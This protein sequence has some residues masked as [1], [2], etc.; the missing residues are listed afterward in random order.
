M[1]NVAIDVLDGVTVHGN[2]VMLTDGGKAVDLLRVANASS[3]QISA[4]DGAAGTTL[5]F[6][7]P[8]TSEGR[9]EIMVTL[10]SGSVTD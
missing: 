9:D 10:G 4:S 8:P 5:T 7:A 2:Q 6:V 3:L 1:S